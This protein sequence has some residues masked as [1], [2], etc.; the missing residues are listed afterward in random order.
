MIK[1]I[2]Y[3]MSLHGD[4]LLKL[5]SHQLPDYVLTPPQMKFNPQFIST[6]TDS[7]DVVI[8][9]KNLGK[10]VNDNFIIELTRVFPDNSSET[11]VKNMQATIYADTVAFTLP[12]D[13][14]R[15]VGMNFFT[16][17]LD[18]YYNI[19]ESTETNNTATT[20]LLIT[21]S[22]V[23]PVYPYE[24]AVIPEIHPKLIASTGNPFASMK[25]YILKSTPQILLIVHSNKQVS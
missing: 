20:Q 1:E 11:Y 18:A 25:T 4:P 16:A 23:I 7:F 22:D 6:E 21:S 10:A 15:G 13:L 2:C 19:D 24:Y 9:S 17:T 8:I 12:V 5:N 3:S 14:A